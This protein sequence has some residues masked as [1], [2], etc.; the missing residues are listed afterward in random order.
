[1]EKLGETSEAQ[2]QEKAVKNFHIAYEQTQSTLEKVTGN[3]N[4][5]SR[6]ACADL[7]ASLKSFEKGI[8]KIKSSFDE[9]SHKLSLAE[10]KK[11]S[12]KLDFYRERLC[13]ISDI[14]DKR[15]LADML[16]KTIKEAEQI[17]QWATGYYQESKSRLETS[18]DL[19]QLCGE[20]QA[21]LKQA[22]QMQQGQSFTTEQISQ[23]LDSLA[24]C[25]QKLL[26][27]LGTIGVSKEFV[28]Y[29]IERVKN[30]IHNRV[31]FFRELEE[32]KYVI[33][34]KDSQAFQTYKQC[35]CKIND[36][37]EQTE[38]NMQQNETFTEKQISQVLPN[39]VAVCND[40]SK[41]VDELSNYALCAIG[42]EKSIKQ[43]RSKIEILEGLYECKRYYNKYDE[44]RLKK[45]RRT[46]EFLELQNC[47]RQTNLL[48]E[49][50]ESELQSP[51]SQSSTL[52]EA[53][54]KL[55][56]SCENLQEKQEELKN[57]CQKYRTKLKELMPRLYAEE[58]LRRSSDFPFKVEATHDVVDVLNGATNQATPYHAFED[59]LQNLVQRLVDRNTLEIENAMPDGQGELIAKLKQHEKTLERII[60]DTEKDPIMAIKTLLQEE[61]E[62]KDRTRK[63][64]EASLLE[65]SLNNLSIETVEN[66]NNTMIEYLAKNLAEIGVQIKTIKDELDHVAKNEW[67]Y[68]GFLWLKEV[69]IQLQLAKFDIQKYLPQVEN[70]QSQSLDGD[71][72]E[73]QRLLSQ[74]LQ[75]ACTRMERLLY[76]RKDLLLRAAPPPRVGAT[77]R[78]MMMLG[79]RKMIRGE[80]IMFEDFYEPI[81]EFEQ[82]RREV[83]FIE[84]CF[85]SLEDIKKDLSDSKHIKEAKYAERLELQKNQKRIQNRA[86]PKEDPNYQEI[87]E[88]LRDRIRIVKAENAR[89]TAYDEKVKILEREWE[90]AK[91]DWQKFMDLDAI[92]LLMLQKFFVFD[93]SVE[94]QDMKTL[95]PGYGAELAKQKYPSFDDGVT[96]RLASF[97][98]VIETFKDT[99]EADLQANNEEKKRLGMK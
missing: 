94:G 32:D 12:S 99:Y 2:S 93:P 5:T 74:A 72:P 23:T 77:G 81:R 38:Q 27:E 39:L 95:F 47:I 34:L 85:A 82:N 51:D 19:A 71:F 6:A 28:G 54:D 65:A 40:W 80:E 98:F 16:A 49:K 46:Q 10:L 4:D 86:N 30:H 88:N 17:S 36:I 43:D 26:T 75:D 25:H 64:I 1:M 60:K 14:F 78:E 61:L 97:A 57:K 31:F 66:E 42:I 22:K 79:E 90:Q 76:L 44:K 69:G 62:I 92:R 9:N 7:K 91:D 41:M 8:K 29:V 56:H 15:E 58:A 73:A 63:D 96:W 55:E 33:R 89:L 3:L 20:F 48:M 13:V 68:R 70:S 50:I 11:M 84:S 45:L 21:S 18:E 67:S 53:R 35:R 37:L 52:A 24:I 87:I 83:T 59:S